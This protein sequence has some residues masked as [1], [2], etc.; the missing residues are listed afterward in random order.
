MR[1]VTRDDAIR[2]PRTS[3]TYTRQVREWNCPECDYFEE[4]TEDDGEKAGPGN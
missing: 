1:L 3:E 2:V 4:T